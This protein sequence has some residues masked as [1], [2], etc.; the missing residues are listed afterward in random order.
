MWSQTA[1]NETGIVPQHG[2]LGSGRRYGFTDPADSA[3]RRSDHHRA[4]C[5]RMTAISWL[6]KHIDVRTSYV[7]A[8]LSY[9]TTQ[10]AHDKMRGGGS[11]SRARGSCS[12]SVSVAIGSGIDT[13]DKTLIADDRCVA[14]RR[15]QA[16]RFP[17]T[18]WPVPVPI[19]GTYRVLA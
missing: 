13:D 1:L 15:L 14:S 5:T 18:I 9:G 19:V 7:E 12:H 11:E 3:V 16:A 6:A 2:T 4:G 8:M 10:V 17:P